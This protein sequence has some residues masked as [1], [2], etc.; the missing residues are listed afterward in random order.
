MKKAIVAVAVLLV[1]LSVAGW[2]AWSIHLAGGDG[3]S[4]TDGRFIQHA[5]TVN[6]TLRW[7]VWQRFGSDHG[8]SFADA[9][10]T[11]TARAMRLPTSDE[12]AELMST[13][14]DME[15]ALDTCAFPGEVSIIVLGGDAT[16]RGYWT[17]S[18]PPYI[19]VLDAKPG[20][21]SRAIVSREREQVST[22]GGSIN[23]AEQYHVRCVRDLWP[24]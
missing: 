14:P 8:L 5:D 4:C 9:E 11:C 22:S 10:A 17:S 13:G 16:A 24:P 3:V 20:P 2:R 6:D 1:I 19:P 18:S 21:D 7:L 23:D 12:L 15:H